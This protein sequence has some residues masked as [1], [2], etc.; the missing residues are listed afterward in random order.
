MTKWGLSEHNRKRGR[1]KEEKREGGRG[2]GRK[3]RQG[4]ERQRREDRERN[5]GKL[6]APR[7]DS[8]EWTT[9][10]LRNPHSLPE[11]ED[12]LDFPRKDLG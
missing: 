4:K 12:A 3:E 2:G 9:G 5:S 8:H 6:L 11:E 10:S 1:R 7:M